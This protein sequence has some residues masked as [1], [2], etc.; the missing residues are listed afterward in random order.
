MNWIK[1]ILGLKTEK[2][3]TIHNVINLGCDCKNNLYHSDN[4]EWC[5]KEQ[6]RIKPHKQPC[7]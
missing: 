4:N 1:K 2:Q 7:L 3:C 6:K 5:Y